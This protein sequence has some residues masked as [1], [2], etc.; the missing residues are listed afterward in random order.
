MIINSGSAN[1]NT[2]NYL[3]F[4]EEKNPLDKNQFFIFELNKSKAPSFKKT[5]SPITIG[6][7]SKLIDQQYRVIYCLT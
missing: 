1:D 6:S 3:I 5:Y 7:S 4:S 2:T